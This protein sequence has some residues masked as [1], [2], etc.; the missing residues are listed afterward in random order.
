MLT[1]ANKS[2]ALV[3]FDGISIIK[4]KHNPIPIKASAEQDFNKW[5]IHI[6][7]HLIHL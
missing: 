5:F 2:A 6:I 7:I 3:V 1:N 4:Y